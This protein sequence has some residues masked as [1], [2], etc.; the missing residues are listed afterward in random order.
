M[1]IELGEY[2][3]L[4]D[5]MIDGLKIVQD[6]RLYRFTSD[7]VLLSRFAKA[8]KKDR[9]ADF[10]AG[11]G[12]VAFHFYALNKS[13]PGLTFTLFEMQKSLSDLS[14]KTAVYNDFDNFE[15]VNCKLQDIPE[16]YREQ[17]SL[18]LCN[19][20]YERAGTGFN[21]D[22]YEKAVC[23]KEITLTLKEIAKAASFA[24]KFGGRVCMLHRA[25]RIAEVC[26]ELKAVN[27]EV[28]KIQF[29]GGRYGSKPYLVMVEGVKGGKPACDILETIINE[30]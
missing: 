8:K 6:T 9:V 14:K 24:L 30:R 13:A 16:E 5:M 7:S 28:K 1:D 3:V 11:S 10:C 22:E 2:E 17:Y 23:R 27:I 12:I 15:I 26:Y 4:E 25:D 18:V 20:P 21:N 29:V 19:P